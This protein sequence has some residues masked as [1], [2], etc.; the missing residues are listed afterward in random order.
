MVRLSRELFLRLRRPALFSLFGLVV[1]TIAL[2]LSFPAERAKQ[3][4]IRIAATKDLDV[5]I[6]SAS[7]AFGL[8]VVFRDILVRTKPATGKPTRFTVAEARISLSPWSLLSSARTTTIALEAF[9]GHV[10]ITQTGAPG[11]KGPFELKV[12]A[13]QVNLG[14]LPGVR[15]AINLPL[16]GT[17]KLDLDVASA[18]GKLAEA[19]GEISLSCDQ[20]VLGDGKT[21][22]KVA[23]NPFLSGGLTLPRVRL[24]D[25]GGHV[26]IDKGMAKLQ[27]IGGKS[28]DGEVALEGEVTLRDPLPSSTV[29]AYLRFKFTDAFL[30][31]ASAV[32]TILQVAGAQGK[33]PDGFYGMRLSGRLGQMNPPVLSPTSPVI[34]TPPPGRSGTRAAI[35][36]AVRPPVPAPSA[37]PAPAAPEPAT[38]AQAAP[39]PTPPPEPAP[40]P[41]SPSPPPAPA[42]SPP[43]P[44]PAPPASPVASPSSPSPSSPS[45]SSPAP[46][47]PGWHGPTPQP[48]GPAVADAHPTP[49]AQ[50]QPG[51]GGA[52]PQQ[53]PPPPPPAAGEP[54]PS[55]SPPPPGPTPPP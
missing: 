11:K 10:E 31:Q 30:K 41:P 17:A 22:L 37:P 42:A 5:E 38:I 48:P 43:A 28:P 33:R 26:A 6:G 36:P 34:G 3:V 52:M 44:S 32:Q 13:R 53:S 49:P 39:P 55:Q 45:P 15:D 40:A 54:P 23:G 46:Q 7:P 24:A 1:F 51:A 47:Q 16:S 4:A 9:G 14:E 35:T 29:N 50:Q 8:G 20:V 19:N 25:F 27:E 12:R 2:Y 18:S 21:P